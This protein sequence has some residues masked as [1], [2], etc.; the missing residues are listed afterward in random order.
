MLQD[1]CAQQA[2]KRTWRCQFGVQELLAGECRETTRLGDLHRVSIVVDT[3]TA[4]LAEE[5][6]STDA[7]AN[8]QDTTKS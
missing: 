4:A 5:Q 3:D 8:I 1:M 6:V 7:T 2:V